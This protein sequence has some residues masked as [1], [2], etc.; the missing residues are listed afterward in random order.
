[1]TFYFNKSYKVFQV[2]AKD[3]PSFHAIAQ[4]YTE[5]SSIYDFWTEPRSLEEPIDIMVP[6]AYTETFER[7]LQTHNLEHRIK[8]ADVQRFVTDNEMLNPHQHKT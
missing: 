7:L 1:M 5:Q 3:L 2:K 6:P 4:L 8:I